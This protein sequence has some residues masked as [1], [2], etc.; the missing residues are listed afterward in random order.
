MADRFV[1]P[2][3]GG[4]A[5]SPDEYLSNRKGFGQQ[6]T[7][8][9]LN[10]QLR[11]GASLR[12][13]SSRLKAEARS[14][15]AQAA[16]IKTRMREVVFA[17]SR[18]AEIGAEAAIDFL[19]RAMNSK[20]P[21]IPV[22]TGTLRDSW[23]VNKRYKNGKRTVEFE[24]GFSAPYAFIVHEKVDVVGN[25]GYIYDKEYRKQYRGWT[26]P[27]SGAKWFQIALRREQDRMYRIILRSIGRL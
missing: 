14:L 21:L 19:Y 20:P 8:R 10:R 18:N 13:Q 7:R 6:I 27:N 12:F 11:P 3:L 4:G 5:L 9:R 16:G 22:K 24:M 26:R 1:I 17:V 23:F 25:K 15:E 2:K